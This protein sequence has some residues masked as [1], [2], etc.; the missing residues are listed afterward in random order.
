LTRFLKDIESPTDLKKLGLDDLPVLA[1]E[2]REQI[3]DT[4]SRTGGH[5]ASNLGAV[6]LTIAMHYVFDSPSDRIIWDVGHQAYTHKLLTGRREG[7]DTLRQL[8]GI[9]GFPN[10]NESE[11]DIFSVGHSG[12][13]ISSGIGL[14][15]GNFLNGEPDRRVLVVI[16]DGSMTAGLAYEG[17][18]T[19]GRL[20]KNL[21][22]VLNDNEMS[23][24][25]NV[26]ALSG[27]L[28]RKLA[29]QTANAVRQR[30]KKFL[31]SMPTV[32]DDAYRTAKRMQDAVKAFMAPGFLFESLGFRYIGPIDGHNIEHLIEAFRGVVRFDTPVLVHVSTTK[33]K[34]FLAAEDT[35]HKFHG[36]GKFDIATGVAVQ[37]APGPPDYTQVFSDAMLKL[38][39]A[40]PR[41]VAITAAMPSGTG[42]EAFG[43]RFPERSYDV[44]ICEQ[45]G[46]TFAAGLAKTGLRPV[47]AIYSTFLQRSY[48]QIIHDVALQKLPV[49]FAVDRGGLVGDDGP[50]HHGVFDL[51]YLRHIPGLVIMAPS[52]EAE[53]VNM[54]HSAFTYD[55][56]VAIRY[57]RGS[58]EGVPI[59]ATP[60]ILPQGKGRLVREGA[61]AVIVGIGNLVNTAQAVAETLAAE[62]ID[63]AV[64]DARFVKPL[65][66]DLIATWAEKTGCLITAEENTGLGGFGGAVLEALSARGVFG[67]KTRLVALPDRFIEQGPQPDL[68]RRVGIDETGLAAAVRE[69]HGR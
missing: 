56:P 15:E 36:V 25:E 34:G 23:I 39:E 59:P 1:Q 32:G 64:I 9:S 13:S 69:L 22:I 49:V 2:V 45:H 58:G 68:R 37:K 27:Y 11:H 41:I 52:N 66:I 33:G 61:D 12:T 19:A 4:V 54:L 63:V 10:P 6:E 7:F 57:P 30:L 5:L 17:L 24:S 38:G 28:S 42:L 21:I 46:I 44:G 8:D 31:R 3:I 60:E 51:S 20:D 16:G 62:G 47:A 29:G 65:D 48:D 26:G 50:T 53:M 55:A 67:V 35:P 18:N 40:D 14:V 43:E